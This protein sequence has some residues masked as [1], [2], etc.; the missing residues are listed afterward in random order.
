[1]ALSRVVVSGYYG[2]GNAGDEL[3][4]GVLCRALVGHQVTVLSADP[5]ATA[6]EHAVD[7]V[8]RMEPRAILGALSRADL[9]ISGGGG[10]L[11][12]ASG[13]WTVPYYLGV[14]AVAR[15]MG[16]RVMVYAQGIGPLR[17]P[18]AR[19]GVRLLRGAAAVTV[20]DPESREML[21]RAGVRGVQLTADAALCLEAPARDGGL[22]PELAALGVDP[23][24]PI[25]AVAPRPY[26]AAEFSAGLAAAV[27][28]VAARTG[29]QVVLVAMQRREDSVAC[30][31]LAG[32]LASGAVMLPSEVSPT[33]YPEVF[34]AFDAVVGMRLHALILAALARIPAVGLS[35]DPKIR[36][37]AQG[38]HPDIAD[39]PLDS[40]PD[41]ISAAVVERMA[42]AD[43]RRPVLDHAVSDLQALA[44]QNNTI[45]GR[46]LASL[47]EGRGQLPRSDRA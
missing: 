19:A 9:L 3:I 14:V 38:L 1:M 40:P 33:R 10:L 28:A 25:L 46:L 8:P 7:A 47:P 45:L 32:L 36:A 43:A 34:T 39:L 24:R 37:F 20:R 42:T 35:Y 18:W 17:A 21:Q 12:D 29:A 13:P 27:D 5:E 31:A 16:R 4:L 22:P 15:A 41:A 23:G 30:R 6:R 26:G 11:Q 2:F 44:A